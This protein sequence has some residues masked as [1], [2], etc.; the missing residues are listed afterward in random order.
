M[1]V[2]IKLKKE[3][4]DELKKKHNTNTLGKLINYDTGQ[5]LLRGEANITV[6]NLY[7]LCK[8]MGWD[9]PDFLEAEEIKEK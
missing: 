5:K 3:Y 7:K 1:G 6:R 9:F 2:N 8:D 4:L